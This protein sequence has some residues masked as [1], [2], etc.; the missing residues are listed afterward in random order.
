MQ[1]P[2]FESRSLL[3][4]PQSNSDVMSCSWALS[5]VSQASRPNGE[6]AE[7]DANTGKRGSQNDS[8][9]G[10]DTLHKQLAFQIA[11]DTLRKA[12]EA[13]PGTK[14]SFWSYKMY[15]GPEGQEVKVHYCKS[16]HTTER[17]AQY[18]VNEKAI[19]FDIEWKTDSNKN[20]GIK[21][22]VSLIQIASETRIGLFHIAA[23]AKDTVSDLVA[24]TFKKIMEDSNITKVGVAVKA[25]CTRLRNFLEVDSRG[26][27]ELSHLYKLVRHLSSG[28]I[29]L[30]NKKLVSL[31]TQAEQYLELPIFKGDVRG[32]DWSQPLGMDQI[33]CKYRSG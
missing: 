16:K 29:G 25:D 6:A 27:F 23:F 28:D 11:K 19:G 10:N 7:N 30:I 12:K 13:T 14:E 5:S 4:A 8:D 33:I 32:S 2:H 9:G 18:F 22:N 1:A 24:P 15:S 17:V 21:S 31:S 20:S 26:L 3:T